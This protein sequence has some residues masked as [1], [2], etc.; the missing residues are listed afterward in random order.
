MK[1][2]DIVVGKVY[3]QK[4]RPSM[5]FAYPVLVL[6]KDLWQVNSNFAGVTM[7]R[8]AAP[9]EKAGT[10]KSGWTYGRNVETVG[11]PILRLAVENRDFW[12]STQIERRISSNVNVEEILGKARDT[13]GVLGLIA[14]DHDGR[15]TKENRVGMTV[16]AAM[17]DGSTDELRVDFDVVRPQQIIGGWAEYLT[18]SE[19]EF[20]ESL[21]RA[22]RQREIAAERRDA[23]LD[24]IS[25]AE[26]LTDMDSSCEPHRGIDGWFQISREMLTKLVEAAEKGSP[27]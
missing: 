18:A 14:D 4:N 24:I 17:A 11:I 1:T 16:E 10:T 2:S 23:D 12:E 3:A 6:A 13:M 7:V 26:T 9:G 5:F 25:R 21:R 8:K 15:P 19:E 22:E 20:R 27:R